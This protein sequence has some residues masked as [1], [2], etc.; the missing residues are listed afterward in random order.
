[1]TE[2]N[3]ELGNTIIARL[4][5]ITAAI[6]AIDALLADADALDTAALVVTADG[7]S[8]LTVGDTT[9]ARTELGTKKTALE[10][11]ATA[12]QTQFDDL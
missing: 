8:S 6:A 4:A 11:E 10:A 2:E 5:S 9:A 1:M 7:Y 12:L 3:L